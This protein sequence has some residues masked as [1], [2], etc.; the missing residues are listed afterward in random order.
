MGNRRTLVLLGV[1]FVALAVALGVYFWRRSGGAE[2]SP[3]EATPEAAAPQVNI[4]VALNNLDRGTELQEGLVDAV[5]WPLDRLPP[6]YQDGVYYEDPEDVYGFTLRSF[7]PQ[8]MPLMRSMLSEGP[9]RLDEEGSEVSLSIPAGKRALAIP[10]DL[11]GGVAWLI[12]PGDHVDVLASWTFVDLDEEFQTPLPNRWV[13]LECPE[14]FLCSGTMGRM[15]LL[16]TGQS[17]FVY[18][19]GPGMTRYVAQLTVQDAVVLR[20][21]S[22]EEAAPAAEGEGAA[23]EGEA[24]PPPAI[25][26]A[27]P[28]VLVVDTQD[29]LVLKALLELQ[30][31]L[32][33]VLRGADDHDPA[34]ASQVSWDYLLSAYQVE[35][36]PKLPYGAIAPAL[37]RLQQALMD[38]AADELRQSGQ[39][40]G[41]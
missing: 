7:V 21:G 24:P 9:L 1:V 39:S 34:V 26:S 10:M 3:E 23:V 32:D 8:G 2:P 14:G 13:I 12:Q 22:R 15:E 35:P 36:P 5:S 19:E 4:V 40:G 16:P 41:E 18:P 31:D 11:L 38:S 29:A 17:V 20:V 28:V 30:A 27:Q 37:N 25:P 33:L 6:Y